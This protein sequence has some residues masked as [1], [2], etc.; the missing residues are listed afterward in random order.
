ML[1]AADISAMTNREMLAR[2]IMVSVRSRLLCFSR[3]KNGRVI[4]FAEFVSQ[5]IEHLLALF[6]KPSEDE[7][8][9]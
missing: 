9:I 8:Y 1:L 7:H 2:L 5:R 3:S 4:P 6:G